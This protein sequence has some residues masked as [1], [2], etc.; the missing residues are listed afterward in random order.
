M[1]LREIK[2]NNKYKDYNL[3]ILFF[4]QEINYK[5]LKHKVI[6]YIYILVR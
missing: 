1:C 6:I 4:G 2:I 3:M 5:I